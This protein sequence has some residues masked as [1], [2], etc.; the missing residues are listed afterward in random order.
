MRRANIGQRSGEDASND[1]M[2]YALL[3]VVYS[4]AMDE[5]A[6][7]VTTTYVVTAQRKKKWW[8]LEM[9]VD[10]G[11]IRARVRRLDQA[12]AL[13]RK[14]VA[15]RSGGSPRDFA[16]EISVELSPEIHGQLERTREAFHQAATARAHAALLGHGTAKS[17]KKRGLGKR[18]IGVLMGVS[19]GRV[20]TLL[21]E[22]RTGRET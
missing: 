19:K 20:S 3:F 12:S 5:S 17:L 16:I 18:D 14:T 4:G 22:Y 13:A 15:H 21:G 6:D 9:T 1:D 2:R 7:Y 8:L 10:A 11:P